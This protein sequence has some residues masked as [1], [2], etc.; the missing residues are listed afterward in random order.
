MTDYKILLIFGCGL[1]L[2]LAAYA[3]GRLLV[4]QHAKA[5]AKILKNMMEGTE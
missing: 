5:R 3:V 1:G 2:V 4:A